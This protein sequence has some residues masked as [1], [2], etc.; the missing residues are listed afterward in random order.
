[1]PPALVLPS[2][3]SALGILFGKRL[4]GDVVCYAKRHLYTSVANANLVI[5]ILMY[6]IFSE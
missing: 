3:N 4:V 6:L 5:S 1:M 2:F